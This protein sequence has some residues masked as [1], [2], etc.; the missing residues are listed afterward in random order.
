MRMP[1]D[2][3]QDLLPLYH[4]EVCSQTSREAVEEHLQDCS[5]CQKVL[6]AMGGELLTPEEKE[7]EKELRPL[8]EWWKKQKKKDHLNAI[9]Y[10]MFLVVILGVGY[11]FATWYVEIPVS[12]ENLEVSHVY[13][14]SD[15]RIAFN[16]FVEGD[17][18]H[19]YWKYD[20]EGNVYLI[21]ERMFPAKPDRGD[22]MGWNDSIEFYIPPNEGDTLRPETVTTEL[23]FG[24]KAVYVGP[25]GKGILVWEEGE[26]IP[27][28]SEEWEELIER[29]YEDYG[30]E[31][32]EAVSQE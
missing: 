30:L 10:T 23:A 4:D 8:A 29:F 17:C 32:R 20:G 12:P 9:V 7:E 22:P 1:C 27:K 25:I 3:I 24:T 26:E 13:E 21:P 19:Y 11:Y 18:S 14:L 16:L 28:A 31:Y 15:G 6:D 2:L 5:T